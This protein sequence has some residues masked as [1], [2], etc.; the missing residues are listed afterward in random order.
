MCWDFLCHSFKYLLLLFS[1]MAERELK[2]MKAIELMRAMSRD[3]VP[4]SFSYWS[5]NETKKESEGL[6]TEEK[7]I[8]QTGYR[9]NQSDKSEILVSFL[10]ISTGER[11]QFYLPLLH[12]LNG[13]KVKV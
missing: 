10:R 3:N 2:L 6:K 4:F 12:S 8:L 7:T 1:H 13:I 9:R 11:R 5:F